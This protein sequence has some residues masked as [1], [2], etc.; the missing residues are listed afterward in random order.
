MNQP[1]ENIVKNSRLEGVF[2]KL[3]AEKKPAL[4]SYIMAG[5]PSA[6][7]SAELMQNLAKAGSDIIELGMPFSDPTAD[8]PTIQRAAI[9]SLKQGTNLKSVFEQLYNFRKINQNTP[10]I[11][12]G[13]FN[14]ILHYGI[15]EFCHD[16][17]LAGADG[18]IIVDLPIE[19]SGE[20][21]GF[22]AD[23]NLHIIRLLA[24]TTPDERIDEVLKNA[25]GFVY[26]ISMTGTTGTKA[27]NPSTVVPHLSRLRK[28][29]NL[30]I[31]VGFGV[32]TAEQAEEIGKFA[33]AVVV[34]SAIVDLIG[35]N[36]DSFNAANLNTL[37][38]KIVADVFEFVVSIS[39][40]LKTLIK[41]Q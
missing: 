8:G 17:E 12:M 31:A 40:K 41:L 7:I 33:D 9:R 18:L 30:P 24:P 19:E 38:H 21:E 23:H 35:K 25:S 39:K 3:A 20:I 37:R 4:I 6:E 22:A 1:L 32:K 15:K 26:F 2:A 27:V 10:V 36:T 14:P 5:D 16:A 11:L 34:G 13:Y 28:H 29:T